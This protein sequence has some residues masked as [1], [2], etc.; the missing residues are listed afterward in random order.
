MVFYDYSLLNNIANSKNMN[1]FI[2]E[3][4]S[5][6][7]SVNANVFIYFGI[8]RKSSNNKYLLLYLKLTAGQMFV[9]SKILEREL[10][11]QNVKLFI[12]SRN[13]NCL[14]KLG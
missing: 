5:L 4:V 13:S 1:I 7:Q 14:K 3:F 6:T 2:F 8:E 11:N 12:G 10:R 9:L